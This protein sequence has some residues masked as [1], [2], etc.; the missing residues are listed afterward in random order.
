MDRSK[1]TKLD[2][3]TIEVHDIE[4]AL[5]FYIEIIGLDEIETPSEVKDKGVRWLSIPGGQAL[6]LIEKPDMKE[7]ASAHF[8]IVIDD[9]DSWQ[10]H[11]TQNQIEIQSPKFDIYNA[12][13]F[14]IKD[15]SGNRIEFL[16]WLK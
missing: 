12:Q 13:R 1:I 3:I 8:A 15:P 14:F 11:L 6:H 16:K 10:K 2:H 4:T 9:P 5:Q 7:P